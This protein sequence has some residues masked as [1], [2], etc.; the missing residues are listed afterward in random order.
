MPSQAV[1]DLVK[2]LEA[3]FG[4]PKR[5][6]ASYT[7]EQ[8]KSK[9]DADVR[10][11]R[12]KAFHEALVP[13]DPYAGAN[14]IASSLQN[15]P[16]WKA[17]AR[18]T[19]VQ[20]QYCR[21]CNSHTEFVAQEFILYQNKRLRASIQSPELITHQP[22]GTPLPY[23]VEEYHHEVD[24]CASCLRLSRSVDDL[25]AIAAVRNMPCQQPLAFPAAPPKP[26]LIVVK[27]LIL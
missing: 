11:S 8:K 24:A 13:P 7:P 15:Q 26:A 14:A 6:K 10:K 21:I 18:L 23:R 27:E 19:A 1:M 9:E 3:E 17:V 22:D 4:K 5:T 16:G 12:N 20:H 25:L 2:Q